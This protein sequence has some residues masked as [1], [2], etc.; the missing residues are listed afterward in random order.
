MKASNIQ[1]TIKDNLSKA[2][3][4]MV[5]N[6]ESNFPKNVF[7]EEYRKKQKKRLQLARNIFMELSELPFVFLSIRKR[8]LVML[9]ILEL[10]VKLKQ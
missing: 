2:Q 10:Q 1:D 8:A 6:M 5:K 4:N 3:Q 7:D 9:K